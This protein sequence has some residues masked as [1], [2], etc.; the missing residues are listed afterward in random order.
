MPSMHPEQPSQRDGCS[1]METM[2]AQYRKF[3]EECEQLA[4]MERNERYRGVLKEMAEAWKKLA[5]E[6]DKS[7]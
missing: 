2:A 6:A 3:A 4:K 7:A 1:G 5:A